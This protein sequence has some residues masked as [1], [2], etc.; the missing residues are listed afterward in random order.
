M[1]D[2]ERFQQ[3]IETLESQ[4]ALLGDAAVDAAV[5]ALREKLGEPVAPAP[6]EAQ[7][8]QITVLFADLSGFTAMAEAMDA[9]EVTALMNSLWERLDRTVVE[10]GGAIDKHIGD[11]VMALW[12]AEQAREDDPERALRAALAMQAGVRA[13]SEERRLARPLGLRVGVNTGPVLLGKMGT[14]GEYTAMGDTVNTASRLEGAAPVG[15]VLISQ[16]TYRHIQGLFDVR[17]LEP[18][19]VKGKR[20]ALR[21]Y[22]ILKA[23]ARAF[24]LSARGVEGIETHMVGRGAELERLQTL[25][26]AAMAGPSARFV[27]VVGDA[28]IGKSRLLYEFDRWVRLLPE[29]VFYF[30]GRA[31]AEG[32]DVPYGLFR[33]LFSL[34]FD[35]RESDST[36]AMREKFTQGMRGILEADRA[37]VVGHFLGFDFSGSEAV[38]RLLGNPSFGKLAQADLALYFRTLARSPA[39]VFLEDLHWADDSSLDLL[40]QLAGE[41]AGTRLLLV[42][43]ARPS[44]FERRPH[45][46]PGGA[47]HLRLELAL[48][49]QEQCRRLVGDI[50]QRVEELPDSLRERVVEGAEGNPFYVEELIKMLIEVGVIVRGAERWHVEEGKLARV[51]L[52]PTLTGVIQARLDSIPKREKA[53]LQKASVVGRQFWDAVLTE[54]GEGEGHPLLTPEEVT[55][56]LEAAS[57]RELV[58]P[59]KFSAF[60]DAREY[61]F[62]HAL[63]RDV[64]YET[65]LL[66]TRKVYHGQVARWLEAHVGERRTEYLNPIARHFE[67]AGE[68]GRAAHYLLESGRELHRVSAFR[69]AVSARERALALLPPEGTQ[70]RMGALADLGNSCRFLGEYAKSK[71]CFQESLAAAEQLGDDAAQVAA[72]TGLGRAAQEVGDYEEAGAH[73]TR[74]L[75]LCRDHGT[76]EAL[77]GVLHSLADMHFRLG[78]ADESERCAGQSLAINEALG[79]RQGIAMAHRVLGFAAMMRGEHEEAG[80]HHEEH[81]RISAELGDRWGVATSLTNV[82]E[83]YRKQGLPDEAVACWQKSL[84]LAEEIGNRLGVAIAHCNSGNVLAL[85]EGR[86]REATVHLCQALLLAREIGSVPI[87]LEGFVGIMHLKV[88]DGL[89][90]EAAE[91][92]GMVEAHPRFNAEIKGYLEPVLDEL[93]RRMSESALLTAKGRGAALDLDAVIDRTVKAPPDQA[94]GR[95]RPSTPSP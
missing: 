29:G 76:Q 4:R 1:T 77:A 36:A 66:R 69:D 72:H 75:D 25:L 70:S 39:V 89:P 27:T 81:G 73:L 19:G 47:T 18:V 87:A 57:G 61:I 22:L 42:G 7:R 50:L 51:Q 65:V 31:T 21:V 62:K 52:P 82:G 90:E 3:A 23:K 40:G 68:P 14:T 5:A 2:R 24:R 13:F 20:E 33:D 74:A 43:L 78:R 6:S 60:E 10:H 84:S 95:T 48:L 12:G 91:L 94:A 55:A 67:L 44:L 9:E 56:L 92:A 28:G 88:R 83:I 63:L 85:M 58:F 11:N 64:T 37:E 49:S 93:R 54:L 59:V 79:N 80:R 38:R 32:A 35:I 53:L 45:W 46:A 30:K 16:D 15:G 34:R 41:V 86:E 26:R 71:A 8:K 17:A